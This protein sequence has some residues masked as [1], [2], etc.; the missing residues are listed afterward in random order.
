MMNSST[1]I[2]KNK[3][4]TKKFFLSKFTRVS[5]VAKVLYNS[6]DGANHFRNLNYLYNMTKSF[7]CT[8]ENPLKKQISKAEMFEIERLSI[9]G[10]LDV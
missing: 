5:Q 4:T 3:E 2:E 9:S 1:K 6:P 8:K 10:F 7:I